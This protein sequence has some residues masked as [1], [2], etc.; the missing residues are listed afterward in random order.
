MTNMTIASSVKLTYIQMAFKEGAGHA[1]P[2]SEPDQWQPPRRWS[3]RKSEGEARH[4]LRDFCICHIEVH[5]TDHVEMNRRNWDERAAIHARDTTVII[6]LT[7]FVQ[8][9]TLYMQLKRPNSVT[10]PESAF[11]IC[12][13]ILVGIHCVWCGAARLLPVSI[14]LVPR[15]VLRGVC[16]MRLA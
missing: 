1:S 2:G 16:P 10:F 13:A 14:F 12:S 4:S 3:L 7:G 8:A 9:R 11:C 6:C 5:M 15:C